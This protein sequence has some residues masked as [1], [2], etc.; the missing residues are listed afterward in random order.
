MLSNL[1]L[2]TRL[3]AGFGVLVALS[4]LIA[5][6]GAWNL[7]HLGD[8][9]GE[10]AR[11]GT[12]HDKL[13]QAIN[14]LEVVRRAQLRFVHDGDEAALS[15][16]KQ[17][18]ARAK[19][20]FGSLGGETRDQVRRDLYARMGTRVDEQIA[21]AGKLEELLRVQITGRQEMFRR[22][23]ALTAA[24]GRLIDGVNGDEMP[25]IGNAEIGRA[26]CRERV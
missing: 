5:G 10:I 25:G 21:D 22:G 6:F 2:R 23:D 20:L 1:R 3:R 18:E 14:E 8:L 4:L 15:R 9:A 16:L 26:S 12:N 7:G 13:M 19:E 24:M 17:A 11:K